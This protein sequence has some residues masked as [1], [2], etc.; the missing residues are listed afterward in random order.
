MF[1]YGTNTI[2]IGKKEDKL[3]LSVVIIALLSL[4]VL[5]YFNQAQGVDCNDREGCKKVEN[6]E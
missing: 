1:K 2:T 5:G 4:F 3:I 6:Y